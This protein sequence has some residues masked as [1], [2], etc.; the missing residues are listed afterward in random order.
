MALVVLFVM[1][2]FVAC[3]NEPEATAAPAAGD[4]PAIPNSNTPISAVG[5]AEKAVI[6]DMISDLADIF[7]DFGKGI[8]RAVA[9]PTFRGSVTI[10]TADGSL[11]EEGTTISYSGITGSLV[12]GG[13]GVLNLEVTGSFAVNADKYEFSVSGNLL[14]S[15]GTV[16]RNG[17]EIDPD[18][19]ENQPFMVMLYTA[20]MASVSDAT[21]SIEDFS[22]SNWTVSGVSI[23]GYLNGT[24]KAKAEISM[25]EAVSA[26]GSVTIE[27]LDGSLD[28]DGIK[29]TI[30][31]D[32]LSVSLKRLSVANVDK[33]AGVVSRAFAIDGGFSCSKFAISAEYEG[34]KLRLSETDSKFS[35]DMDM[36]YDEK[37]GK[38]SNM[39]ASIFVKASYRLGAGLKVNSNSIGFVVD[40][41]MD[42]NLV[43]KEGGYIG[44][45]I[46][47]DLFD[48]TPLAATINGKYVNAQQF[49]DAVMELAGD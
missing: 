13:K 10:T 46:D 28:I 26:S 43:E 7:E 3:K 39:D 27:N 48:F 37:E 14:E 17:I 44:I 36:S 33:G 29:A 41:G 15:S 32:N 24:I 34:V 2:A 47:E 6:Q 23:S 8:S 31:I 40:L 42:G 25:N 20:M 49:L 16:K 4:V 30:D 22:C 12:G 38:T 21:V 9:A 45:G 11:I 18:A 5:T 19:E 1:L 35:L